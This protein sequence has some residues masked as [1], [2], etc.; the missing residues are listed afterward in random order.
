MKFFLLILS[1]FIFSYEALSQSLFDSN[2][3]EVNFI[4]N[5]VDEEKKNKINYIK[6]KSIDNIFK[7]ILINEDYAVIKRNL[8]QDLINFFIKNIIVE[9]E[10]IINNNYFSEVKINFDK[11]KIINYLRNNK[12]P[13][14]EILPDRFL[15]LI[16]ESNDL[17]KNLFSK[18]NLHYKYLIS[19]NPYN[20]FFQI[21]NLD[22]NDRYLLNI[23]NIQNLDKTKILKFIEKYNFDSSVII[24]SIESKNNIEYKVYLFTNNDLLEINNFIIDQYDYDALFKKIKENIL[25]HWKIQNQI[26]NI[27][28]NKINCNVKYFNVLELKQIKKNMNNVSTIES[29]KLNKI[30][31]QSN[32]YNII[33]FGNKK[34]LPKLFN[35]NNLN[36]TFNDNKCKIILK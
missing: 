21:P 5:N 35:M 20:N 18:N 23:D 12:I 34:I 32:N 25:D 22:I 4:S 1:I 8:D 31:F 13:Y 9:N 17:Q 27:K 14:V 6:N 30:S 33:F 28:T 16:Y 10:K 15:T 36:I 7:N 26:Q 24:K 29:I 11:K 19:K 2:F 3:N